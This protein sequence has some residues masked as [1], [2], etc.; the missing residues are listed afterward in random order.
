MNKDFSNK[1]VEI[2][3]KLESIKKDFEQG[4]IAHPEFQNQLINLLHISNDVCAEEWKRELNFLDKPVELQKTLNTMYEAFI[5]SN[6][7]DDK[8]TRTKTFVLY[9]HL[10]KIF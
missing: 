7:S 4:K 9:K 8:E 6:Y 1:Q 3:E 2:L 5:T 10:K